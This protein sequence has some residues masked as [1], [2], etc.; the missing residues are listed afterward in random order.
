M[1]L[2]MLLTGP[3]DLADV[4]GGVRKGFSEEMMLEDER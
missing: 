3:F 1:A 4:C 2:R